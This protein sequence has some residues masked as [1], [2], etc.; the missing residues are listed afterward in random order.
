MSNELSV[1]C[2]VK[3]IHFVV[4]LRDSE[5][6]IGW[7]LQVPIWSLVTII[8]RINSGN[9]SAFSMTLYSTVLVALNIHLIRRTSRRWED[10]CCLYLTYGLWASTC[11]CINSI[12]LPIPPTA[13]LPSCLWSLRIFPCLPDSRLPGAIFYRHVRSALLHLVKQIATIKCT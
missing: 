12:R 7:Y 11:Y 6:S 8:V 3:T 5:S 9:V 13:T 10:M 2:K 4:I 1:T